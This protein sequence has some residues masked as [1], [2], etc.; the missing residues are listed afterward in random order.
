MKITDRA[1]VTAGLAERRG[2]P[3]RVEQEVPVSGSFQVVSPVRERCKGQVVPTHKRTR[4]YRAYEWASVF[5]NRLYGADD[6]ARY[7]W[8]LSKSFCMFSAKVGSACTNV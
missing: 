7:M 3:G 1:V 6:S 4:V 2:L 5:S 8:N